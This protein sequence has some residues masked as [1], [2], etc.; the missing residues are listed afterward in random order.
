M[1]QEGRGGK[2]MLIQITLHN[3]DINNMRNE[4]INVIVNNV[5]C[6]SD[7]LHNGN[8]CGRL[9]FPNGQDLRVKETRAEIEKL[10]EN[11]IKAHSE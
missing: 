11:V 5:Y 4:E 7:I 8:Q 6:Y 1:K 9:I 2:I 3:A 10:I